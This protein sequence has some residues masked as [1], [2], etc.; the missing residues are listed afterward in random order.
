MAV[1]AYQLHQMVQ[2]TLQNACAA[3]ENWMELLITVA[4]FYKYDFSSALQIT[5]QRPDATACATMRQW[6]RH[7]LWIRRGSRAIYTVDPQRPYYV[8]RVFDISD[9]N[10]SPDQLCHAALHR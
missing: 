8:Q 5:A 6:N 1:S 3:P 4:P 10:A 2:E 9:V 7:N